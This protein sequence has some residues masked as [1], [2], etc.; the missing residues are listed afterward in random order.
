MGISRASF[1]RI[2]GQSAAAV[3]HTGD[4]TETTLATITVP[5]GAMGAN[6][7]IEIR[8]RFSYSGSGGNRTARIKFGGTATATT[9]VAST[10]TSLRMEAEIENRNATNSQYYSGI[11][12]SNSNIAGGQVTGTTALDTT[13]S[14]DITITGQLVSGADTMTLESYQVILFPKP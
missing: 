11:A 9:T 13:A 10:I 5:A 2:L 7:H 8:P 14:V 12:V 6:G 4:T 1:G 3:S